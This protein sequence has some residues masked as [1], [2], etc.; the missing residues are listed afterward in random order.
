MA[1]DDSVNPSSRAG[2]AGIRRLQIPQFD[3][4]I[5]S[6]AGAKLRSSLR[7]AASVAR[8]RVPLQALLAN[9][10]N[11]EL[12]LLHRC[13][14]LNR[15][16]EHLSSDFEIHLINEFIVFTDPDAVANT[17]AAY[18][19]DPLWEGPEFARFLA[20]EH[21]CGNCLDVGCGS[22]V[23]GIAMARRCEEVVAL[24]L[25]PRAIELTTF[26]AALNGIRNLRC[27]QCDLFEALTATPFE[28]IVFNSPVDG[29][30]TGQPQLLSTGEKLIERFFGALPRYLSLTGVCQVNFEVCD[31]PTSPW[32]GRLAAWLGPSASEFSGRIWIREF[33]AMSDG[34]V[35]WRGW[36]TLRRDSGSFLDFV[37]DLPDARRE[38]TVSGLFDPCR[39]S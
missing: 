5:L 2:V 30:P 32:A 37:S 29:V 4:A 21:A 28:R 36:L 10:S 19:V 16:G 12:D 6:R 31:N 11:S 3:P 7:T 18:F 24:D 38:I 35:V 9:L 22:G 33:K 23:L 26:N 14:S 13:G 27:V 34:T 25:N 1:C 8:R 20:Q 17:Q 39:F 15:D